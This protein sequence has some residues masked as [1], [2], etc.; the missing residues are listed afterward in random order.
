MEFPQM[1]REHLLVTKF[2][3]ANRARVLGLHAAL[4]FQVFVQRIP[5]TI[6][7]PAIFAFRPL[8]LA[9]LLPQVSMVR[10]LPRIRFTAHPALVERVVP[11]VVASYHRGPSWNRNFP[12]RSIDVSSPPPPSQENVLDRQTILPCHVSW[13][14][15]NNNNNNVSSVW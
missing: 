10:R 6:L 14:Y 2:S 11:L 3:P 9:A 15:N 13:Y 1:G 8:L 5:P 4:V 7:P 12:V